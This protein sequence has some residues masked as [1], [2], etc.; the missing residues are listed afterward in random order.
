MSDKR[1]TATTRAGKQCKRTAVDGEN[2]CGTH[3]K[4]R[5][6]AKAPQNVVNLREARREHN[7]GRMSQAEY[8]AFL[9]QM[10]RGNVCELKQTS[11]GETIEIPPSNKDRIMA[12]QELKRLRGWGGDSDDATLDAVAD[13]VRARLGL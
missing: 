12:G 1:C 6:E 8:E 3:L 11:K 13:I 7:D 2:V 4:V 5:K 9:E 10:V